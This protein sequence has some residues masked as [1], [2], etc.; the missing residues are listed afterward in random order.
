VL[1]PSLASGGVT[2]VRIRAMP[3]LITVLR[4]LERLLALAI[5]SRAN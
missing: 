2:T 5:D 1:N 4:S 3:P